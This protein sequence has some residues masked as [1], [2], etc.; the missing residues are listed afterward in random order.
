[1]SVTEAPAPLPVGRLGFARHEDVDVFVK[2]LE[3]FENGELTPDQWRSFR[4]L[5]GVYGQRQDG[6]YMV[7][8]KLPAGIV[9]PAQLHA[10]ADVPVLDEVP[11]LVLRRAEEASTTAIVTFRSPPWWRRAWGWLRYGGWRWA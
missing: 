5:N 2:R 6:V 10:L 4:L 11:E 9:T 7:R 3:A 8:A 1:M